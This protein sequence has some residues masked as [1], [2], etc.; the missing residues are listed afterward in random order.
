[1]A[2]WESGSSGGSGGAPF[3]DRSSVPSRARL[4]AVEVHA[5]NVV[6]AVRCIFRKRS[7]ELLELERHGGSGGQVH[8]L[9]LADGEHITRVS[10]RYANLVDSVTIATNFRPDALRAGGRGGAASFSY[11]AGAG[12]EIAGL[13]GRAGTF[14][15]ALGVV[16][17]RPAAGGAPAPVFRCGP[18]GGGDGTPFDT[19]EGRGATARPVR[20]RIRADRFLDAIQVDYREGGRTSTGERHGGGGGNPAELRLGRNEYVTSVSGRRGSLVDYIVIDTNQRKRALSAGYRLRYF[21]PRSPFNAEYRFDAPEGCE[22]AGFFG[23]SGS[24]VD[25]LGVIYRARPTQ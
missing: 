7:G 12:L 21:E 6:D 23:R 20:I 11:E 22:I 24:Y 2:G 14:I 19:L 5:H 1:M 18:T 8:R 15:D 4:V 10:G 13:T 9:E 3:S 17:R 16:F 25:A